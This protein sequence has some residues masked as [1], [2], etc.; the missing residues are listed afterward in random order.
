MRSTHEPPPRISPVLLSSM[1]DRFAP[2]HAPHTRN[3][4]LTSLPASLLCPATTAS[5]IAYSILH[6]RPLSHSQGATTTVGQGC[7][8]G[9]RRSLIPCADDGDRL[10]TTRRKKAHPSLHTHILS[11][12]LIQARIFHAR[13]S[14]SPIP[15]AKRKAYS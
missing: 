6:H 13:L 8:M 12:S 7:P 5:H 9:A 10:G 14:L 3:R 15:S 2:S 4:A 1:L 11:L